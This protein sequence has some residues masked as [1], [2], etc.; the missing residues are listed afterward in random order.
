VSVIGPYRQ[1]LPA[2]A[3]FENPIALALEDVARETARRGFVL[4]RQNCSNAY[5]GLRLQRAR[6]FHSRPG[7][8]NRRKNANAGAT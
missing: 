7:G 6:G 5:G 3:R 4:D 1:R 8:L 2:G